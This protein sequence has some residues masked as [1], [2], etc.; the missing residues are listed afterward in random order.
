MLKNELYDLQHWL[1]AETQRN[2]DTEQSNRSQFNDTPT[3]RPPYSVT[4][5]VS[6]LLFR[7]IAVEYVTAY[8]RIGDKEK[9]FTW[10]E[11]AT[12]EHNRFAVE[13]RINPIYDSI[14]ND[15]RFQSLVESVKVV[16]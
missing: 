12:Q 11:K 4:Y 8:T 6:L 2:R 3:T 1:N 13:F 14:R 9:A 10:L 5:S 15:P 7:V 16:Q